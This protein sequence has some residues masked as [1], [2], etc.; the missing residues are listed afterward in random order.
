[1]RPHTALFAI[2]STRSARAAILG[3]GL[4]TLVVSGCAPRGHDDSIV[5]I[6]IAADLKR[7]NMQTVLR[8]AELAIDRLNSEG[9]G[10]HFELAKPPARAT[11]AVEI[12]AAF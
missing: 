1:M 11:G 7:P 6:G 10:G 4:G 8:G 12:A 3:L 5:R 2:P 9:A